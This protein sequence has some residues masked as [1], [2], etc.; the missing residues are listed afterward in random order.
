VNSS[1]YLTIEEVARQLGRMPD[2][3]KE[4]ICEGRIDAT[5]SGNRWMVSLET[6]E[7][8]QSNL[9]PTEISNTV[10]NFVPDE[11]PNKGNNMSRRSSAQRRKPSDPSHKSLKSAAVSRKRAKAGKVKHPTLTQRVL[12]LDQEFSRLTTK[13][14]R[15]LS[16]G[17][18]S[19]G[20]GSKSKQ[21]DN[22]IREWKKAKSEL[23]HLLHKAHNKDLAL[24]TDLNIYRIL[25]RESRGVDQRSARE[26]NQKHT[27]PPA[28]VKG[29][30]GYHGGPR[31][32]EPQQAPTR[33]AE[34]EAR[35][36]IL[37][38]RERA[39]AHD[40]QDRAKSREAREA[41]GIKWARARREAEALERET[42]LLSEDLLSSFSGV[43][44]S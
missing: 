30:D 34:I 18:T 10:R 1:N 33:P 5:L 19:A 9:S 26:D 31:H 28:V 22:R 35:L 25:G 37:R 17:K 21:A 12:K 23:Q 6:F 36:I 39:A 38:N 40:M 42:E 4:Q 2:W 15:T 44:P 11:A 24:P 3:V 41:A 16:G 32:A 8:L 43:R 20:S 13:L 29:I 27:K 14:E 7:T